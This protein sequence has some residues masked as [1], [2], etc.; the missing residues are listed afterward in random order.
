MKAIFKVLSHHLSES[1]LAEVQNIAD[2]IQ[3]RIRRYQK[4]SAKKSTG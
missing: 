4:G 3:E 2:E 1:D